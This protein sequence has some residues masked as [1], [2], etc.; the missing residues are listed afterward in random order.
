[1]ELRRIPLAKLSLTLG[2][3]RRIPEPAIKAM[4]ESFR[5]KGQ[6]SPVVA[7]QG[8]DGVLVLVDGFVRQL[9]ATRLGLDTLL[10]EVVDLSPVQMKAQLYLRN[11]ERGLLLIEECRLVRDLVEADGLGQVEVADLLE[12]HKSWVCRRLALIRQVSPNLVEEAEL[13]LL[14][15]GSLR[16]LAQVPPRNQEE[17]WA[18][19]RRAELGPGEVS[20]VIDL[21]RR[22]PDAESRSFV[23][24]EPREAIRLARNVP[25]TKRDVRLGAAGEEVLMALHILRRTSLRVVHRLRDGLGEVAPEGVAKLAESHQKARADSQEA[26]GQLGQ[27]LLQRGEG[28]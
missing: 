15:G 9:A 3:L 20:A 8:Q 7:S 19:T 6:L 16:K 11:R 25:E 21:W 14:T 1:V 22:A 2:R 5:A 26:L 4:T 23:L 13:G 10:A 17:V 12:C 27:W 18:A 24:S 28:K